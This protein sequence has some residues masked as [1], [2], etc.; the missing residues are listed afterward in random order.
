MAAFGKLQIDITQRTVF[1]IRVGECNVLKTDIG[2]HGIRIPVCRIL[3]G[4]FGN[5]LNPRQ[6]LTI[7]NLEVLERSQLSKG[8]REQ[9]AQ[10]QGKDET[11]YGQF[12]RT[13]QP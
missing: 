7:D 13:H 2:L 6:R 9:S 5:R 4:Y 3:C 12:A 1:L 8:G 10:Y 11:C